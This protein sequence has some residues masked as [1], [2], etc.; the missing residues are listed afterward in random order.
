MIPARPPKRRPQQTGPWR[1][2][3]RPRRPRPRLSP[4]RSRGVDQARAERAEA[5]VEAKPAALMA[6]VAHMPAIVRASTATQAMPATA[7]MAATAAMVAIVAIPTTAAM[8]AAAAMAVTAAIA[9]AATAAMA[10]TVAT[11]PK[12][13]LQM[14]M[15]KAMGTVAMAKAMVAAVGRRQ[16]KAAHGGTDLVDDIQKSVPLPLRLPRSGSLVFAASG[17]FWFLTLSLPAPWPFGSSYLLLCLPSSH[18]GTHILCVC[19]SHACNYV[20]RK[21]CNQQPE[22][23]WVAFLFT[24][25]F[26]AFKPLAQSAGRVA[27]EGG[28]GAEWKP[29]EANVSSQLLPSG[30]YAVH[31]KQSESY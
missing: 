12:A 25:I 26:G 17:R 16:A 19:A 30:C 4:G 22:V 31:A 29:H 2:Q 13:T 28:S 6:K 9:M 7:L 11:A 5:R 23:W 24:I 15:P 1:W 8:A 27:E 14:A 21:R 18:F 20:L 10:A 3:K